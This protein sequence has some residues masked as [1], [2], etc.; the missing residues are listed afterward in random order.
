MCFFI[1]L[2][3]QRIF[4]FEFSSRPSYWIR[5]SSS[6][7]PGANRPTCRLIELLAEFSFSFWRRERRLNWRHHFYALFHVA[8]G[9]VMVE[10][11][12]LMM[13]YY[14]L[15]RIRLAAACTPIFGLFL[16]NPM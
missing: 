15:S 7:C 2:V 16:N 5:S 14:Y 11:L 8:V 10:R 3:E 1:C 12:V 6:L 9:R 4:I 13:N